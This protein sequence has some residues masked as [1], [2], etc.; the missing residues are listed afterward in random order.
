MRRGVLTLGLMLLT[1]VVVGGLPS[2]PRPVEA[3]GLIQLIIIDAVREA[4]LVLVDA[5]EPC[6]RAARERVATCVANFRVG[7]VR[8]RPHGVVIAYDPPSKWATPTWSYRST[9]VSRPKVVYREWP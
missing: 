1:T 4:T 5:P 2:S 9:G 6:V 8:V 7:E 3:P